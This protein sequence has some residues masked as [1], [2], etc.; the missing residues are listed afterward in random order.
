MRNKFE[1]IL[2]YFHGLSIAWHTSHSS[3][4]LVAWHVDA[5]L[6]NI[7]RLL[8]DKGKRIEVLQMA[9]F[10]PLFRLVETKYSVSFRD[11]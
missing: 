3:P 5:L 1:R 7:F 6:M 10:F 8:N 2:G 11:L 4:S 9:A